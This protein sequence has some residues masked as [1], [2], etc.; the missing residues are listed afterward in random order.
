MTTPQTTRRHVMF[1]IVLV[2]L[3]VCGGLAWATHSVIQL[4]RKEARDAAEKAYREDRMLA[5]YRIHDVVAP[6]LW[7]ESGRPFEH[8]RYEYK[9]AEARNQKTNV[10]VS[11]TTLVPSPLQ[12][13]P[14]TPW[15]LMHFI[16]IGK[17]NVKNG[18]ERSYANLAPGQ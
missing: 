7:R 3:L 2:W 16:Q 10:D 8:Y 14:S 4:E 1:A 13:V 18:H 6:V 9:P 17:Q 12:L 5:I 15:I 11:R